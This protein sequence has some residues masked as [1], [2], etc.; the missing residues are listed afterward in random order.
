MKKIYISGKMTGMCEET[1]RILFLCASSLITCYGH[2]AINPWSIN[3]R[4]PNASYEEKMEEDLRIIRTDADA[5]YMLANWKSSPGAQREYA[6]AIEAG[7]PVYYESD[8]SIFVFDLML[9]NKELEVK[10]VN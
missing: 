10:P 6:A 7:I 3:D 8:P 9:N 2:E 5:I 1:S 4:M